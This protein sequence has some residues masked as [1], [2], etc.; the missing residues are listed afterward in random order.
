MAKEILNENEIQEQSTSKK[1]NVLYREHLEYT[2]QKI[3]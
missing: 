2:A 3:F 1:S